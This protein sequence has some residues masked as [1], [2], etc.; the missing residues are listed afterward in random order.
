[1]ETPQ[2]PANEFDLR[3]S[4]SELKQSLERLRANVR[5]ISER[6]PPKLER[7]EKIVAKLG[8]DKIAKRVLCPGEYL[9]QWKDYLNRER[10]TLDW[11][12]VRGL[13]WEPEVVIDIRFHH[14]LDQNWPDL[15]A[16]SLQ[17][18]VRGCHMRW[19]PELANG[20]AV[21]QVR[22]RLEKYQ[23]LNRLLNR[24][25]GASVMLLGPN[26]A[27]IF[28]QEIIRRQSSIPDACKDWKLDEQSGY[29]A[30]AA[31]EA[32]NLFLSAKMT[33]TD[34]NQRLIGLLRWNHWA[35]NKLKRIVGKTILHPLA[36]SS[37]GWRGELIKFTLNHRQLG[38][39]RLDSTRWAG[40]QEEARKRFVQWL[41][42]ADIV[43]FFDHVLRGNDRHGRRKF[44]LKYVG[45]LIQSRPL[46]RNEDEIR[47]STEIRRSQGVIASYGQVTGV[48]SSFLLDFGSIV[49]VE[50]SDSGAIHFYDKD[51]FNQIVPN[52][53]QRGRFYESRLKQRIRARGWV[54]H[55]QDWE[56][57]AGSILAQYGVR[58]GH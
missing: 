28:A 52:L 9:Q 11:R 47:L 26:G 55:R 7:L 57:E 29:V 33:E 5:A 27:Q 1:M 42:K 6:Q 35:P 58:P 15:K 24:S 23:G 45:S 39:P 14:F 36:E 25:R 10:T 17:G 32:A 50:F 51:T 31:E 30:T 22:R 54:A 48:A 38:D 53:W 19:T 49:A 8:E 4:L 43:F 18:M 16:R 2:A 46:L 12:V 41:S 37:E 34:A 13:C 56:Y 21:G 3:S 20:A 40:V 44:W